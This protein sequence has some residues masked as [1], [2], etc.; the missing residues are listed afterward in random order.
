L[1]PPRADTE[2]EVRVPRAGKIV[3]RVTDKD[4]KPI[5]GAYVGRNTSGSTLSIT[6]LYVACDAQGRFEYDDAVPPDQ[7]SRLSAAAPGYVE[8]QRD[9]LLVPPGPKHLKVNFR[10]RPKPGTPAKAPAPGDDKQRFVSGIVRAPG[11]K[12]V[13]GVVVRWGYEHVVGAIQMKTDAKGRFR[14]TVPDVAGMVAVLPRDYPPEFPR[15]LAGGDK[16]VDVNLRFGNTARGRVVDDT[17]KPIKD[18][19]VIAVV[20]SPNPGLANPYWLT[21]AVVRTDADGKFELKGVPDQAR[22]DFLKPDMSDLRNQELDVTRADNRVTMQYGGAVTG[23]VVDQGGKPLRSFR[24]LVG[25]PRQRQMGD[26]T[27]GFFA[28]YSGMGVR[29]TSE[30]G[31]FVLTGVGAGSVYRIT[32]L[33]EGHGAAIEDRVLAVPLNRLKTAKPVT[34]QAGPAVALRVRAVTA[35]GKPLAD[36]RVTLVN[37][38]P[39]LDQSF[40]W[41]YHNASWEDMARARTGA[42]GMAKFPALSFGEATLLVEAAGYARHR[43]G[44]RNG[45]QEMTAK[46]PPEAVIAGEVRDVNGAPLKEFQVSLSSGGDQINASAGPDAKGRFR[47]AELPAG[48]WGFTVRAGTSTL[49]QEQITLEAGKTKQLKIETQMER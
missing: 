42:D 6:A 24:V 16:E 5:A 43:I 47:I 41:G 4:D 1:I 10:L 28:G 33:A 39:G 12:P 26:Q 45:Q 40:S 29:F 14:L 27:E 19:R 25:F 2:L 7:P 31:S 11:G 38:D 48:V 21:E 49:Y 15:V 17:G 34:L 3:G 9:G 46:L 20:P 37:G 30:D 32:A 8:E 44:W 36:A 18:V 23:R 22:F 13:A 35:G